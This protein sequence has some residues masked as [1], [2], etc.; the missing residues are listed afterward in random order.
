MAEVLSH[1]PVDKVPQ[2]NPVDVYEMFE[3]RHWWYVAR[4]RIIIPLVER[5]APPGTDR[6]IVDVGCGAG[7]NLAAFADGYDCVGIDVSGDLVAAA[8]KRFPG[9]TFIAGDAPGD[10]GDIVGKADVFLLMDVIEHI[11]DDLGYFARLVSAARPGAVFFLTVPA[12]PELWSLH[13]DAVGHLR[14]YTP[15]TLRA[16]WTGLAADELLV[17]YFNSYLRPLITLTRAVN[18][19]RER[20]AGKT[21]DFAMPMWP[22]NPIL[23]AIMG[24]E[25]RVLAGVLSGKRRVGFRTGVSLAAVVRKRVS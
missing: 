1:K 25:G 16:L 13:D 12:D 14:R 9:I 4:R 11:K 5:L 3:D 15:E 19:R 21:T 6:I 20:T 10:L 17:A 7:A 24:S 2:P 22:L 23:A 8:R 18:N